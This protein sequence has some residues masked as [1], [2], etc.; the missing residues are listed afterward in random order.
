MQ[1]NKY[2][3]FISPYLLFRYRDTT[4]AQLTRPS[5]I[6][7]SAVNAERE[8]TSRWL[9]WWMRGGRGR[10]W[11]AKKKSPVHGEKPSRK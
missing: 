5:P 9:V 2:N 8:P 1:K 7:T 3:I 10:G 11:Q 6:D 4:K